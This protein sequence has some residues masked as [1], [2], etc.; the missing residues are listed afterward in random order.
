MSWKIELITLS[1]D[2]RKVLN[3]DHS[4]VRFGRVESVRNGG[5]VLKNDIVLDALA[6]SRFHGLFTASGATC[7]LEDLESTNGTF[8]WSEKGWSRI[9]GKVQ[10][11]LP[12]VIRLANAYRLNMDWQVDPNE[13]AAREEDTTGVTVLHSLEGVRRDE[14]ILVLDQC[15]SSEIANMSDQMAYNLKLRLSQIADKLVP[16]FHP[17]FAKSTG[18]GFLYTFATAVDALNAA[19]KLA[20]AIEKRN[21]RS[22]NPPIHFRIALHYG[23]VYAI[24]TA[25]ADVHGNDINIAFRIEGVKENALDRIPDYFPK[26]DR[27]LSSEDFC[28]RWLETAPDAMGLSYTYCGAATLKGISEPVGIFHIRDAGEEVAV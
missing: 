9:S 8:L 21:A 24:P 12:A 20:R 26:E 13:S 7:L 28:R 10:F 14:A 11:R 15:G 17:T 3:F 23:K 6:I 4:Q 5:L 18:D 19:A 25:G 1:D 16:P 22:N 27:I 2:S